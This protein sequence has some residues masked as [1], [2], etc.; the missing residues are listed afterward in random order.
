[1]AEI[2]EDGA[3]DRADYSQTLCR[4]L[5]QSAETFARCRR[6]DARDV[7]HR[8]PSGFFIRNRRSRGDPVRRDNGIRLPP[9]TPF[10]I[11]KLLLE[12]CAEIRW[13]GVA[14]GTRIERARRSSITLMQDSSWTN[15]AS[16]LRSRWWR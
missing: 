2:L 13:P 1:M 8:S 16:A 6:N 4:T 9:S 7:L 12:F 3:G 10:V 5:D 15:V 14:V 11:A